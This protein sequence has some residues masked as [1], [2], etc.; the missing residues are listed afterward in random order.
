MMHS[1]L[2][3]QVEE[4]AAILN[5]RINL[6]SS[7]NKQIVIVPKEC[8]SYDPKMVWCTVCVPIPKTGYLDR[9]HRGQ[10]TIH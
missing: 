8:S 2:W 9:V 1:V 5:Y 6:R 10:S 3:D 4:V 7:G